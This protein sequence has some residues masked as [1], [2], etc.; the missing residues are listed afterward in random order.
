MTTS[1]Q[2]LHDAASQPDPRVRLLLEAAAAPTEPG[3]APGEERALAAFREVHDPASPPTTRRPTGRVGVMTSLGVAA[4]LTLG[5]GAAVAGGLPGAAQDKAEEVLTSLGV[6]PAG[7]DD[8]AAGHSETRGRSAEAPDPTAPV[9]TITGGERTGKPSG[10]P[11]GKGAAVS[12]VPRSTGSTARGNGVAL[13]AEAAGGTNQAGEPGGSPGT[14]PETTETTE[15]TGPTG[16]TGSSQT[17]E[18]PGR[19]DDAGRPGD[20]GRPASAGKPDSAGK[21]QT[22]GRSAEKRPEDSY[23]A[24]EPDLPE[25]AGARG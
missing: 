9:T 3:P 5:S 6:E 11:S 4:L 23:R 10:E 14:G 17:P 2:D 18:A 8:H 19:P 12:A 13:T 16:P 20:V 15:T 25:A 1:T 7:A 24:A 21:P 22:T